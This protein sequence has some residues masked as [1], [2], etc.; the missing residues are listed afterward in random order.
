MYSREYC[1]KSDYS[2]LVKLFRMPDVEALSGKFRI[3]TPTHS[4][5]PR[6]RE[7]YAIPNLIGCF[8]SLLMVELCAFSTLYTCCKALGS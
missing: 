7:S 3:T 8:A 1:S 6:Q 2:N 4:V 5:S